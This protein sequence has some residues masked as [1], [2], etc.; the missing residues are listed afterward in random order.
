MFGLARNLRAPSAVIVLQLRLISSSS[1]HF[2]FLSHGL[3][4]D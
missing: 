2:F 4:V 3:Y 1:S